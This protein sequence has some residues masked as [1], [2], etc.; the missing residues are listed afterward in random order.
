MALGND[1][2]IKN[3]SIE[4]IRPNTYQPRKYFSQEGLEELTDS[5]KTYGVLQ[6]ITIRANGSKYYEL[7]AGER[8]LRASKLAGLTEIPAIIIDV[9]D[10][11]SAILALIENLQREDLNYIEEA[12][13]FESLIK[14]HNYTQ[15]QLA[16]L[17][18]KKQS[19]IANKLRILR[20]SPKVKAKLMEYGLTERHARALLKLPDEAMQLSVLEK[21][22][23]SGYNV[24]KTEEIIEIELAKLEVAASEDNKK[25]Q[26]I[27]KAIMNAKIYINTIK[28]SMEKNGI[29]AQYSFVDKDE[30]IEVMVKIPK[31]I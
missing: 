25:G 6:P 7:I 26:R 4:L 30:Y 17:I 1:R 31:T 22:Q 21:I 16:E 12:E 28:S 14:D 15:E 19:T 10:G 5:I 9:T 3:I 2:E 29:N 8:R 27:K 11:D 13:G 20:L 18:G 23:K 24:K